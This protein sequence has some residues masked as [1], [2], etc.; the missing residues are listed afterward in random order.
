MNALQQQA[1]ARRMPCVAGHFHALFDAGPAELEHLAGL[2]LRLLGG[3]RTRTPAQRV[4]ELLALALPQARLE[5][6]PEA[7]HLG[8]ISHGPAF[9]AWLAPARRERQEARA[10]ACA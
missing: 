8:P 1:L 3:G 7:G 5:F 9:A 10:Q 2:P 6:L 4:S